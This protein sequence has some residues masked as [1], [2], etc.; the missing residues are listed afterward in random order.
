MQ[1]IPVC[2]M[3]LLVFAG[4]ALARAETSL[5]ETRSTLEKWVESR[6]LISQTRAGW[7][8]EKETIDQTIQLFERELKSLNEQLST[9][10]TNSTQVESERTV[11]LAE[12]TELVN[13]ADALKRVATGLEQKLTVL[14]PL[15]P[16][17]LAEKIQPL[18]K[19]I[20]A[21]PAVTK[22][23]GVERMQ[24][25]V[26]ILNEVDK[27]NSAVTVVSEIQKSPSG[28]E[29]QVETI[30]LGLAQAYFVDK[31]GAYSGIG[32]PGT[33]GWEWTARNELA[34]KIQ[35]SIAIYKNAEPAAFVNLPVQIK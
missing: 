5:T 17:P 8:T 34:T 30:Y 20:P 14:A 9:V 13:A 2:L 18:L 22:M 26:G 21:D 1:L 35:K 33:K 11:A 23:S 4:G 31:S 19:R 24:N 32:L 3:L 10:S 16:Q 7:Q 12:Q 15:F 29:V 27:F 25:L 6:Q 28:A